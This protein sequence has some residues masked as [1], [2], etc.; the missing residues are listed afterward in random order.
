ME[1]TKWLFI[2]SGALLCALIF[3]SVV[4]CASAPAVQEFAV[5]SD[6]D[7]ESYMGVWYEVARI[8]NRFEKNLQQVTAEYTLMEDGYVRVRNKGYNTEKDKPSYIEGKARFRGSTTE[9][10]LEVSFFGPFYSDYNVVALDGDYEYA[11]VCGATYDYLWFLSR[12]PTIPD[13]IKAKYESIAAS[14]GYD[15][16]ALVWI[17]HK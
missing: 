3:V 16:E 8:D 4:G 1:K 9:G 7:L 6:F 5:V 10:S 11:L 17:D 12:T 2:S 13:D 15:I 14:L